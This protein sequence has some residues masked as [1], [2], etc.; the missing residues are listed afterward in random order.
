MENTT[1]DP[2]RNNDAPINKS[3]AQNK[4][5]KSPLKRGKK[6]I[7]YDDK[8]L[9]IDSK[10]LSYFEKGS[11]MKQ[12]NDYQFLMSWLSSLQGV[13]E[14]RKLQVHMKLMYVLL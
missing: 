14:E 2:S 8:F 4:H 6:R 3:P 11:H 1:S 13:P 9:E 12:Y 10:T 7:N 5:F